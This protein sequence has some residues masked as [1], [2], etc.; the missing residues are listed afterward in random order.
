M[1]KKKADSEKQPS[2][3]IIVLNWNGAKDTI[4]CLDSLKKI[5]YPNYRIIVVDNGSTDG[6]PE[7]IRKEFPYVTLIKNKENL[8][9][10]EG[11][12]TGIRK[13]K[14]KYVLL[15]NNDIVVDRNFLKELVK[16][17]E[18]DE[19]IAIAGPKI[20][21][22]H[23]PNKIWFAGGTL[24]LKSWRTQTITSI[25]INEI[26]KGQFD[27]VRECSYITGCCMLVRM[28]IIKKVGLMDS[29]LFVYGDDVDWSAR[30]TIAGYKLV[31]VPEAKIWHKISVSTGGARSPFS[32]YYATRHGIIFMKKYAKNKYLHFFLFY[33]PSRVLKFLLFGEIERLSSFLKGMKDGIQFV[34]KE[35]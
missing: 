10:P 11:M 15:L 14:S 22:H 18:S 24:D 30:M 9:C 7:A 13:A 21:Y 5:N 35:K 31:Y 34:I 16:V 28:S 2:V 23:E 12:N 26:D 17:A 32:T 29:F 4:E 20:Y 3:S 19:K 33:V 6:S 1:L 8:G 25:G 27:N